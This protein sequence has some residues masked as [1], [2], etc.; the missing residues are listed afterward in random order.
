MGY[1]NELPNIAYQSPLPHKNSSKDYVVIK[2]LFR[3]TKL[4]DFLKDNVSLLDN[5]TIGDGD[6]PDMI[7]EESYGDARLDYIVVLVAGITNINHDWPLAD[8]QIYDYVLEKY[9]SEVAM[10]EIKYYKTH[11]IVDDQNRLILPADLIVDKDFK[12]DGTSHKFPSTTRYTLKALTGNRQ[13][14]DKDE[15][16]VLVDNIASAVTNY[17]F[18]I[19][20]NEK[21]REIKTLNR[22]YVQLFKNDLRDI[23]RYDKSSSYI[24]NTHAFTENTNIYSP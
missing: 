19:E 24:N 16:T 15:F 22:E 6:R 5:F 23:V 3:R 21:K 8:Y 17:D 1:F 11:E 13:L 18:E 20:E 7:A 10:N 2:N 9:G 4:F 12:I 14:D